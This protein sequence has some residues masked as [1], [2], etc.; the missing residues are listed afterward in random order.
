M[1][2]AA[3]KLQV[4]DPELLARPLFGALT[5]GGI[6]IANS[7]EPAQTRNTVAKVNIVLAGLA[8]RR[9]DVPPS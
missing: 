6:F 2:A 7:P 1:D 9:A 3:G 5:G 4:E 8:T